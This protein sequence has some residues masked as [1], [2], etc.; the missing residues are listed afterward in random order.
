[1]RAHYSSSPHP[2]LRLD[3]LVGAETY[4]RL[5]FPDGQMAGATEAWGLTQ[6]D[7]GYEE[8]FSDE[9]WATVREAFTN[10]TFVHQ[11]LEWFADDLRAAGCLVDPA[12]AT[13]T[14]FVESR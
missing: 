9:G 13:L 10:E 14:D 5:V 11:V 3:E 4:D 7:P 8:V 12:K 1:M 6:S 2:H